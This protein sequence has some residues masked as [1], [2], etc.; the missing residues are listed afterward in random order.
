MSGC[1]KYVQDVL[2]ASERLG[3]DRSLAA[4]TTSNCSSGIYFDI[5]ANIGLQLRKLYDPDLYPTSPMQRVFKRHFGSDSASRGAVCAYAMEPN[6]KHHAHLEKLAARY[7]RL[8]LVRAAAWTT[9]GVQSFWLNPLLLNGSAHHEWSASLYRMDGNR[10]RINTEV[11][12]VSV[13]DLAQFVLNRTRPRHARNGTVVLKLDIERAEQHVLPHLVKTNAMCRVDEVSVEVHNH[14]AECLLKGFQRFRSRPKTFSA[15]PATSTDE[16]H[17][18][19]STWE[20]G[21]MTDEVGEE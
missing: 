21:W 5:G 15:V 12:N 3:G 17:E 1:I 7:P 19:F 10:R 13:V 11:C 8:T 14:N 2:N 20:G 16:T 18:C 4:D 6:P 9:N